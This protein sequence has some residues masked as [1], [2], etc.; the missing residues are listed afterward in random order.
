MTDGK[1]KGSCRIGVLEQ[2]DYRVG[3]ITRSGG[4]LKAQ[5]DRLAKDGIVVDWATADAG[6]L[7]KLQEAMTGLIASLGPCD[8]LIYHAAAMQSGSP[9]DL[10]ADRMTKEFAVNVLGAHPAAKLVAPFMVAQGRGAILFTGG[11]LA[12]EP[13]PEW[14]SLALGKAALRSLS[15]SLFKEL[16]PKGVHVAILA[17]CG[18]VAKDS[19]FAPSVIAKEYWRVATDPNGIKDREVVIEPKGTDPFYND[20]TGLHVATPLAPA[21]VKSDARQV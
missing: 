14:T 16:K 10:T 20:P 12:L 9:L 6:D 2:R 19:P 15:L 11:G 4:K 7:P 5:A 3:L 13:Y 21:H 17:I 8:V 1:A 18:I